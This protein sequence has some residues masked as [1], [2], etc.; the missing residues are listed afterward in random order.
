MSS[1]VLQILSQ[2]KIFHF[3]IETKRAT[4]PKVFFCKFAVK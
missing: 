3:Y 4:S 2:L 1:N